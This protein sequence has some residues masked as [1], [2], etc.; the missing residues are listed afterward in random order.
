MNMEPSAAVKLRCIVTPSV[1]FFTVKPKVEDDL[2][3][4]KCV[5]G[6]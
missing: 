3:K 1:F 4:R 6:S 2:E 5:Q